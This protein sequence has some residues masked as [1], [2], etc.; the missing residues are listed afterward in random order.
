LIGDKGEDAIVCMR[1]F[2]CVRLLWYI[3][4]NCRCHGNSWRQ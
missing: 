3:R 4:N 2:L 1:L